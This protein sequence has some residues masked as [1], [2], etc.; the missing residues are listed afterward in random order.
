MIA[1]VLHLYTLVGMAS[2]HGAMTFPTPRNAIDATL[3]AFQAWRYPCDGTHKG[4]NCS[5]TCIRRGVEPTI[6]GLRAAR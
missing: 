1:R 3:P 6:L 5:L 4:I 2:G